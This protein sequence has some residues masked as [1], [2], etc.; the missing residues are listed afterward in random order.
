MSTVV[1]AGASLMCPY[2]TGPATLNVSSQSNVI[3]GTPVATIN[4]C[5]PGGNILFPMCIS[6]SNPAYV[7][8]TAAAMG[9]STPV[10]CTPVFPGPWNAEKTTVSIGGSLCLTSGCQLVCGMG[11]TIRITSP[12]QSKL[13]C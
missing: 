12:G 8:A 1:N 11:G 10:P 3:S 5:A 2:A 6:P 4:D 7:A 13:N 9:V